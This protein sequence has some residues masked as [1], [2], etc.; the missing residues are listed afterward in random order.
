M[1]VNAIYELA[2]KLETESIKI[3]SKLISKPIVILPAGRFTSFCVNAL[4]EYDIPV[5]RIA[6]NAK[7][8]IG[9]KIN[10]A[11][12]IYEIASVDDVI[13]ECGNDCNY[14][15]ISKFYRDEIAKQLK[16]ADVKEENIFDAPVYIGGLQDKNS[17]FRKMKVKE[18]EKE[19]N[20]AL[21]YLYDDASKQQLI[22]LLAISI[23]NGL[24]FLNG[25][26][27]EEYFNIPYY[28]LKE[29]EV[30]VDGGMYDGKTSRRFMELCPT[31]SQ[32]YGY[33]ANG[34]QIKIIEE[35]LKQFKYVKI[36]EKALYSKTD[37]L[38]FRTM[39]EG[40]CLDDNGTVVV[41]TISMD[42]CNINPTYIKLDI[43]GAEYAALEG[44]KETVARCSPKLAVAI[45]H[46]L[47]DHWRLINKIK[48]MD[49][50]YNIAVIHH[51]AYDILYG[52][53]LY[54]WKKI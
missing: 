36:Y 16:N 13:K 43:E 2:Q 29:N 49:P 28:T 45:Y 1:D 3:C 20:D 32:V 6:D 54:A 25:Q 9:R 21:S 10:I 24:V 38:Y 4:G 46:S 44:M 19:I 51:Y 33:E 11:N 53:N 27:R 22:T 52:S 17:F 15:I 23:V 47:E 34:E 18:N 26:P 12:K 40:S 48:E 37:K 14:I 5:Q 30:F 8:K 42:E 31:Y 39:G 41:E 35:N 50:E 7:E